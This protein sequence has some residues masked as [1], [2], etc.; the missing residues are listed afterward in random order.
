MATAGFLEP[1]IEAVDFTMRYADVDD[2]WVAQ[3]QM[4][5]RTADADK[6]TGLRHAQRRPR[7]AGGSRDSPFT[8]PDDS[9]I[10]PA[11][12]WVATATA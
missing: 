7:R 8:Q 4:S 3:T 9:L 6:A 10:I 11:R 12:T 5:T 2:W 1:E